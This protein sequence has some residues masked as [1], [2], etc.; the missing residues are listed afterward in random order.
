MSTKELNI[1]I[2]DDNELFRSN[3]KY[4]CEEF[5]NLNVI[6]DTYDGESF[7]ALNNIHEADIILMDIEMPGISGI[8]TTKLLTEVSL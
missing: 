8:I 7:L 2:V 4:Y 5:L 1:I 3:L 6:N